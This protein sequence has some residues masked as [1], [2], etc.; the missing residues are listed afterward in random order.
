[1]ASADFLN[2]D[3]IQFG[4]LVIANAV[5]T[6]TITTSFKGDSIPYSGKSGSYFPQ[7]ITPLRQA[8]SLDMELSLPF[9]DVPRHL[10]SK[11]RNFIDVSLAGVNRIWA[12]KA[13]ELVWQWA[14]VTDITQ[15]YNLSS[16]RYLQL[17]VRFELLEGYWHK[18]DTSKVFLEDYYLC[19]FIASCNPCGDCEKFEC[20][21]QSCNGS[22]MC[23]ECIN[24][25]K[26]CVKCNC[27][28]TGKLDSLCDRIVEGNKSYCS[29]I[30]GDRCK[31]PIRVV[32][33]CVEAYR[34][35]GMYA[36]YGKAFHDDGNG[37]IKGGFNADTAMETTNVQVK[38]VGCFVNPKIRINGVSICI[39]GEFN[40]G[41]ITIDSGTGEIWYSRQKRFAFNHEVNLL[42][43][44]FI[45]NP[46]AFFT[47][48][49]CQNTIEIEGACPGK[50]SSAYVNYEG[51]SL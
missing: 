51:I 25:P 40:C 7:N 48:K 50:N 37:S 11:Y 36:T 29:N 5:K 27:D 14:R 31:N 9:V 30:F 38:L 13:D 3:I 45:E 43:N 2:T 23:R 33:S 22:G 42:N 24:K 16:S 18:A 15:D 39:D 44:A 1:M 35:H 4:D 41:T 12:V 6:Q 32:Y 10:I 28:R 17:S 46:G 49:P 34:R 20:S 47:V 8:T 19:D 21:N 26:I